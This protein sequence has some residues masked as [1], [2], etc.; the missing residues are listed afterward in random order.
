MVGFSV[1]LFKSLEEENS[2]YK[3]TVVEE[4]ELYEER[5]LE[6]YSFPNLSEVIIAEYQNSD[7]IFIKVKD[8]IAQTE[9]MFDA[10]IPGLEYAVIAANQ[11]AKILGLRHS[12]V[13]QI[14]VLTNKLLF[15]EHCR[16]YNIPQ[17]FFYEIESEQDIKR[18]FSPDKSFVLKPTN[19]QASLGV[20]KL[21]SEEDIEEAWEEVNNLDIKEQTV[22]RNI[23]KEFLLEECIQGEEIST[24]AFVQNGNLI[25]LN[26]TDKVTTDGKY[27]V[28]LGHTVPSIKDE[29]IKNKVLF[30]TKKLLRSLKFQNGVLHIEWILTKDG[31]KV[32]E[33]AGRPP[34]DYIFYLIKAAYNFNPYETLIKILSGESI[35]LPVQ[36][37]KGASIRFF[38][39]SNIGTVKEIKG[40]DVLQN[41]ISIV[42]WSINVKIGNKLRETKSSW[43][44]IGHVIVVEDT[45]IK[46]NNIIDNIISKVKIE[47]SPK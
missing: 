18:L 11:L 21:F 40:L 45:P 41:T 25:F 27:S 26:F 12:G 36:A 29:N 30:N 37:K 46:S 20:I 38:N 33:C 14:E 10:V 6:N 8:Y 24:E 23:S 28:E 7:D 15:R 44:R 16:K 5:N 9:V 4:P 32:I 42:D 47:T 17:P 19:R 34:G 3:I 35:E 22:S 31:P 43:D 39:T 2:D 1:A 13:D